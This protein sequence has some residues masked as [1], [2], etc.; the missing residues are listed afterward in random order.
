MDNNNEYDIVLPDNVGFS[1]IYDWLPYSYQRI[2]NILKA[3][4]LYLSFQSGYKAYRYG[5]PYTYD[6]LE[7]GTDQLVRSN[8]T[9]NSLRYTFA[10]MNYPLKESNR[11]PKA[12]Y[13]IECIERA[14]EEQQ[15]KYK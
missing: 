8:V 11:N 5:K 14:N 3:N 15:K 4:G 12:Q 9:I 2:V 10:S 13:F 7:I 6:I 1:K